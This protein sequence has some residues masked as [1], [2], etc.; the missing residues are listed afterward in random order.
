MK[1]SYNFQEFYIPERMMGGIHRYINGRVKPG[2]FLT[3]VL[4]NNLTEACTKAD[5]ENMRNL[6]AYVAYLYNE[7]PEICWGSVEKVTEWLKGK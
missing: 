7:A 1:H 4:Q 2:R 5:N 3:A 6:P